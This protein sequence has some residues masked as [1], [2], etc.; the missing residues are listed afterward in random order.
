MRKRINNKGMTSIEVLISFIIV[1]AITISLFD[2]V[3]SY[4]TKQQ[5]ESYKNVI[6]EFKNSTTKLINNDIIKYKLAAVSKA[7]Y[8][9]DSEKATYK[10]TLYFEKNV[11]NK[12]SCTGNYGAYGCY[13]TLQAVKYSR[14]TETLNSKVDH[15]IYPEVANSSLRNV[16]YP[17]PD[18]GAG[19]DADS[20]EVIKDIRFSSI[21][22][23]NI[24]DNA[25]LDI[26]I[27][28]HELSTFYHVRI[29][30]P[31]NYY[32]LTNPDMPLR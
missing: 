27:F 11:I 24:I 6:T 15:I 5:I 13:K 25:V 14:S 2:T 9:S 19:Y 8:S 10:I 30:A 26:A 16:T 7:G 1:A 21:S 32:S 29:V 22:F 28:H 31:T 23:G 12:S 20:D 17:L 4:K 18:I 3:T